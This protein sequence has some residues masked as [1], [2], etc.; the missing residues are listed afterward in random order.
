MDRRLVL[1]AH[2]GEA[3]NTTML[4]ATILVVWGSVVALP[5]ILLLR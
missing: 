5:V 4:A 3:F 2:L 1:R